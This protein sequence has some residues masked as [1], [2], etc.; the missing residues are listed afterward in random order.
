MENGG[1]S[2]PKPSEA[3]ATK[4]SFQEVT[5]KLDAGGNMYFYLSTEGWLTGLS[6]KVDGWR[7]LG[8]SIPT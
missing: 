6:Q 7:S 1:G 8:D 4:N 5:S 2:A 3:S